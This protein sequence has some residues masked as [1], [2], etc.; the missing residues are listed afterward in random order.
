MLKIRPNVKKMSVVAIASTLKNSITKISSVNF[1][2]VTW[3]FKFFGQ[4]AKKEIEEVTFVF[5][6]LE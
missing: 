3:K 1:K 4:S 6:D 5:E 2:T